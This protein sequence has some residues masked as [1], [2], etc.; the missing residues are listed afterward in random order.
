MN[1]RKPNET[2]AHFRIIVALDKVEETFEGSKII[3]AKTNED[4]D[5]L[6]QASDEG[7]I[8]AMGPACFNHGRFGDKGHPV[9]GD[10]IRFKQYCGYG[11]HEV[12]D[13]GTK[14]NYII[15]NDDDFLTIKG[16]K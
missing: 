14:H 5:H 11:I 9:I 8:V 6:A 7:E 1:A 13:D 12:D 4:R 16:V 15:I 10:R 3:M 2:P